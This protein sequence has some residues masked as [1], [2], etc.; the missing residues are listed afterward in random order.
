MLTKVIYRKYP[1][2]EVI[3]IFPEIPGTIEPHTCTSYMHLGQHA[4]CDPT[5][6]VS[7][8]KPAREEDIADLRRELVRV[9]HAP[10]AEYK[11]LHHTMH[12]ARRR[13]LGRV[14]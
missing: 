13:E 10:M 4:A 3:A 5:H 1:D 9:G 14:V 11:R 2:G 12:E 8:T 7:T 6:V